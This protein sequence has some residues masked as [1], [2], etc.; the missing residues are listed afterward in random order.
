MH[1]IGLA[2]KQTIKRA[3]GTKE[4]RFSRET[5]ICII[6]SRKEADDIISVIY[7]SGAEGHYITKEDCKQAQLPI[8]SKSNKK[9]KVANGKTCKEK[10]VT[11]LPFQTMSTSAR[12][13]DTF[14]EFLHSLMS[15]GKTAGK[16]T[17]SIFTKSS[18]TVHKEQYVFIRMKGKPILIGVRDVH[19]QYHIPL[20][21][22]RGQWQLRY[23]QRKPI[24]SQNSCTH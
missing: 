2:L 23:H 9:A 7:D 22:Q 19:G 20:I 24:R 5:K 17:I 11:Q 18:V 12:T 16:G 1:S 10:F 15:V 3:T 21:Q 8:L 14:T 13:A 6:P 4:V